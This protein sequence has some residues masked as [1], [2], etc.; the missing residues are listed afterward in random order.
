MSSALG[1]QSADRDGSDRT[2]HLVLRHVSGK[3]GQAAWEAMAEQGVREGQVA[4][5]EH[6][7]AR[8]VQ[9]VQ[10]GQTV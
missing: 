2:V 10:A 1:P 5:A 9:L 8:V 4:W 7:D 3:I 6:W